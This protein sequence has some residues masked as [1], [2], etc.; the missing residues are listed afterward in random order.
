VASNN[1]VVMESWQTTPHGWSR[2]GLANQNT[3]LNLKI[4]LHMPDQALFE[5]TLLAVSSPDHPDY[6]KHLTREEV[7]VSCSV[8]YV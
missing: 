2:I 3:R 1:L 5:Q 4:A 8:P 7:K 6:G